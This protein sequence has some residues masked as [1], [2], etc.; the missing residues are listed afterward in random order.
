MQGFIFRM[1]SVPMG[2]SD[3]SADLLGKGFNMMRHSVK[4]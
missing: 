4:H 1:R 2:A 3:G